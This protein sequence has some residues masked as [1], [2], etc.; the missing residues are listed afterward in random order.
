M[1]REMAFSPG[2]AQS[3]ALPRSGPRPKANG[4]YVSSRPRLPQTG[5][6]V[7]CPV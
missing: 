1:I 5:R 2:L 3:D 6:E 4:V 7:T